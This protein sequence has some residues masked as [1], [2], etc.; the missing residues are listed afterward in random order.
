MAKREFVFEVHYGGHIDRRFMNTYIGE[1]I[2]VYKVAIEHDKLSFLVVEGIAK[3]YGYKS[4]DLIYYLVS[5]CTLRNG[6]S[7]MVKAHSGL[8]IVELYINSFSE[9]IPDIGEENSDDGNSDDERG[10]CRIERDDPYWD[11]VDEPDLFVENNDIPGPSMGGGTIE[12]VKRM[13]VGRVGKI[14]MVVGRVKIVSGVKR[15]K[16]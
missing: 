2:D 1:D 16:R 11:E 10:Y 15:V 8:L 6:L 7:E 12:R 5:G 14:V 4:R 9:S 13:M 3:T